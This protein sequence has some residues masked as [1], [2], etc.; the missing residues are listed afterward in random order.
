MKRKE[1]EAVLYKLLSG[2]SDDLVLF[3]QVY[4]WAR[5]NETRHDNDREATLVA[6][7]LLEGSLKVLL[8]HQ[9]GLDRFDKSGKIFESN[10][11]RGAILGTANS[12]ATMAEFLGLID[13]RMQRDI[14]TIN[15]I[16]NVFAHSAQTVDYSHPSIAC[17]CDLETIR[18][19]GDGHRLILQD[20]LLVLDANLTT[21]RSKILHFI[22]MFYLYGGLEPRL[23]G[24][25]FTPNT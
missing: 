16:R 9:F 7:T 5:S 14:R 24:W 8:M 11:D 2:Q 15:L 6:F 10:G 18:P 21:P 3:G 25:V 20:G 19:L 23:R 4:Q 17:L 22:L 12:R 1:H 13:Q